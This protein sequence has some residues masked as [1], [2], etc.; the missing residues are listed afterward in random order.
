[1]PFSETLFRASLYLL[2]IVIP[3]TTM[4]IPVITQ[5]L[6]K[7]STPATATDT[8][9]SSKLT[10]KEIFDI[11]FAL[12][13]Y[14]FP[15]FPFLPP[16]LPLF[17][18]CLRAANLVLF[19]LVFGCLALVGGFPFPPFV[20]I[21]CEPSFIPPSPAWMPRSH[22]LLYTQGST[23]PSDPLGMQ[24][25]PSDSV[26]SSGGQRTMSLAPSSLELNPRYMTM[27]RPLPPSRPLRADSLRKT[28]SS[29]R[30]RLRLDVQ[31]PRATT[32]A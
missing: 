30:Y 3:F 32:V 10:N 2:V 7:S 4:A 22:D 20:V 29:T 24:C 21:D 1:M 17:L 26:L 27:I 23:P 31:V 25:W 5:E 28:W 19:L 12:G 15:L 8:T 16:P 11:V 18:T 14:H 13:E 6:T 9:V